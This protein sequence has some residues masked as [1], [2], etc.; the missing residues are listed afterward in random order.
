MSE[1]VRGNGRKR[2]GARLKA[3]IVGAGWRQCDVALRVGIPEATLTSYTTGRRS[4][5]QAILKAIAKL[6]QVTVEDLMEE[7]EAE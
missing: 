3:A 5:P 6:I 7:E 2:Q 4:P 1:V